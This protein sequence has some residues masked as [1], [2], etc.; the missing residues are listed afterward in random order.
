MLAEITRLHADPGIGRGLYGARRV[1]HELR[2]EGAT[3]VGCPVERLM[4]TAGL[5]GVRCGRAF[6]TTRSDPAATRPPDLVACDFTAAR[7]NQP[8]SV[9]FTYVPRT[10][11]SM[12]TELSLDRLEMALWTRARAG[13]PADAVGHHSHA[14]SQ[15]TSV[16][17]SGRLADVGAMASIGTI[18]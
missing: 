15:Y 7:P 8:W 18:G 9:D 14:G 13:E 16:R 3:V 5:Q 6:V 12:P 11:S 4:R 1:W 2:R 17:Y 10:D